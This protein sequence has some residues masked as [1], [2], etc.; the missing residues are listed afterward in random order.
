MSRKAFIKGTLI[1]TI[2]GAITRLIGFFLRMYLAGKIG[3][4]ELGIY[5]LVLPVC[6]L[7]Y[8]VTISGYEIA[9]SRYVAY[10][11]NRHNPAK[12]KTITF[13]CFISS[14][15]LCITLSLILNFI[16][17][18]AA[19]KIFHNPRCERLIR[20]MLWSC[21]LSCIHC[22]FS[23][24]CIGN[25]KT[26]LPTLSQICEQLVRFICIYII[27]IWI[28]D[29]RLGAY[30]LVAGEIGASIFCIAAYLRKK[31][32]HTP[33]RLSRR[34][35]IKITKMAFTI[36]TNRVFLHILQCVEA[37]LVPM[38]LITHG[39]THDEALYTYGIITGMAVPVILVGSTLAGSVAQMLLPS[40]AKIQKNKEQLT[41]NANLSFL[42]S[43]GFGFICI[44][45]LFAIS[46]VMGTYIFHENMVS[47]YIRL[48]SFSCP[49]MY[50]GT[51][52]KSILH[53]LGLTG[54]VLANSMLS[55]L[56]VIAAIVFVMPHF[57]IDAYIIS[58]II[59]QCI[60]AFLCIAGFK[61]Y[62]KKL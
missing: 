30:G 32:S 50:I 62:I 40:I 8:A 26:A 28:N 41:K 33:A 29:A 43:L 54:K 49:F 39:L 52:Y 2:G 3:F 10:Y 59:A 20:I 46:K 16:S 23:S 15:A 17:P 61:S 47:K 14:L 51:T 58:F 53:A 42:F 25:E 34:Q 31:Q 37:S 45:G 38:M 7:C 5:Q 27:S 4:T 6:G 55:E 60:N 11:K 44:I 35:C 48:M 18:L 56:I 22:I 21:P 24:Y 13:F 19:G 36:S 57:G 1:L 12:A 9:V